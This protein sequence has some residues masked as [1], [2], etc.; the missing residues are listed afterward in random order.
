MVE[1]SV[2]GLAVDA[3]TRSPIVLLRDPARRRQVPIWIDHAQAHN[4]MAGLQ[5]HHYEKPLTHDLMI[6]LLKAGDL[7]VDKVIIHSIEASNFNAVLKLKKNSSNKTEGNTK[8]IDLN[9]RPSDA[10]ALAIR[11]NCKI[12]MFEEVFAETS[13]PIDSN[14]D[15]EDQYEFKKFL[16]TLSPSE[17]IKHLSSRESSPEEAEDSSGDDLKSEE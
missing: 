7:Q 3:S 6:N 12:W 13:I 11:S 14:A 9:A 1:M 15:E 10:I 2:A 16:E 17:L 5:G 4:I 8:S